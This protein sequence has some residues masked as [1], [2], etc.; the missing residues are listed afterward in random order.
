[1]TIV[2]RI[3]IIFLAINYTSVTAQNLLQ[4]GS[5]DSLLNFAERNSS[6]LKNGELQSLSAK[7]TKIA[8]LGNTV[9]FKSSINASWT[10]NINLPVSYLP[11]EAFGGPSGAFKQVSLGQ[12][13]VSNYGITPQL[14]IINPSA[15]ARV[16]SAEVNKQLTEA[17]NLVAKRNLFESIAASYFNALSMQEQLRIMKQNVNAADS[18]VKSVKNKFELGV[19]REQDLNNALINYLTVKDKFEQLTLSLNQNLLSM[20]ILCDISIETEILLT[21]VFTS[22][23]PASTLKQSSSSLNS[24]I[25][26]L[27]RD[28]LKSELKATRLNSFSPTLSL[29]FNQTWQ[30]NSNVGF[31]DS[32]YNKFDAQYVGLKFSLPLPFDANRLS[33]N[34]TT[35]INYSIAQINANHAQLQ[36][37]ASNRQL[38]LEYQKA[39][40]SFTTFKVISE[41]KESNY[42]KSLNQFNEGIISTDVLLTSFMDKINALINYNASL[43][44]LKYSEF[45]IQI[46]NT[47]Q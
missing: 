36:N 18:I 27:Q 17:S 37:Q 34:Y 20:K 39:F 15:W 41:I 46:N 35:M 19:I 16:K 5:V 25:A 28:F 32:P 21:E 24:R 42:I 10:D 26:L 8:A 6:T 13:Y 47:I 3:A 30:R 2:F 31:K 43:A 38:D 1:M 33:A 40:S 44:T 29:V 23:T 11:A 4:F 9:N 7:W 45:K 22:S 14:D 12:Q